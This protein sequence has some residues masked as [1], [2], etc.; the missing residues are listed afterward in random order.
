MTDVSWAY[1]AGQR[2]TQAWNA[3]C[4]QSGA[5]VSCANASYDGT[6]TDGSSVTF[7]FNTSWSGSNPVPTVTLG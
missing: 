1:G 5:A 4:T 3:V 2:S 6:V 7:G